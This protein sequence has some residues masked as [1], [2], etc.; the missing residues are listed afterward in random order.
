MTP[1]T[2]VRVRVARREDQ[3]LTGAVGTVVGAERDH[4]EHPG[5]KFLPV[6]LDRWPQP[7]GLPIAVPVADL[8]RL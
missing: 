4:H 2:R 1:G 5:Y 3:H 6:Q 7:D 8:E